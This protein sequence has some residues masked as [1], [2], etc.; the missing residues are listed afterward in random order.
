MMRRHNL[1]KQKEAAD[2]FDSSRR[3][4]DNTR[5]IH[6]STIRHALS[7]MDGDGINYHNYSDIGRFTRFPKSYRERIFPSTAYGRIDITDV[8]KTGT[9]AVMARDESI[10]I[11]NDMHRLTLPHQRK[12]DYMKIG[13]G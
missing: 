6:A 12:V 5:K 1:S 2:M 11:T 7:S 4:E 8:E 10:R 9:L 13:S 3:D